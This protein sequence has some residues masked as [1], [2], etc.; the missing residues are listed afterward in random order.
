MYGSYAI[1]LFT[2]ISGGI[3][4]QSIDFER[5]DRYDLRVSATDNGSP[6]PLTCYDDVVIR[7]T[8]CNDN[9]PM[10]DNIAFDVCEN[11]SYVIAPQ[12]NAVIVSPLAAFVIGTDLDNRFDTVSNT[13]PDQV[14]YSIIDGNI[15]SAFAIDP[16]TGQISIQNVEIDRETR[17]Q[18]TLTIQLVDTGTQCINAMLTSTSTVRNIFSPTQTFK[19]PGAYLGGFLGFQK[20]QGFWFAVLRNNHGITTQRFINLKK[21]DRLAIENT[22]TCSMI[23]YRL[24]IENVH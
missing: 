2:A 17:D 9:P 1:K 8:N 13:P 3:H 22:D 19:I 16:M 14:T 7:I 21:E 11:N 5:L 10:A 23:R 6:T 4:A 15:G 12:G 18:Y 20:P 24:P